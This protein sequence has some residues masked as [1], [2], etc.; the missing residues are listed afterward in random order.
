[1]GDSRPR[2]EHLPLGQLDLPPLPVLVEQV[3]RPP[4]EQQGV[5]VVGV[6]VVPPVGPGPRLEDPVEFP[7][8]LEPIRLPDGLGGAPLPYIE[9]R[10]STSFPGLIGPED[11]YSNINIFLSKIFLIEFYRGPE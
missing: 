5:L 9:S 2:Y 7:V 11:P 4:P 10:Y 8:V 1:M 6:D 3:P